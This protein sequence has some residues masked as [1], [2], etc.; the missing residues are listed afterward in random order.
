M[1]EVIAVCISEKRGTKKTQTQYL[2][3]KCGYGIIGDAHAG[4]WHRQIS[5][6]AQESVDKMTH[7][8]LELKAGD[9]AE[10]IVTTGIEL[11]KL[12]I[13][14]VLGI[15]SASLRVTQI[16]KKCHNDCN[17][18]KLV[19]HCI[20]PTEGIFAEVLKDGRISPGDRIIIR[21]V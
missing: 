2:D 17:I 5:L 9:F 10:N 4:A 19:G 12:P 11:S 15:G 18:K 13:G 16:G 1:A 7:P 6:L 14:T 20:M 21:E 8:E 3:V